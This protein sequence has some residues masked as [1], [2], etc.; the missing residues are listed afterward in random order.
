[1]TP[2]SSG[3]VVD[4]VTG[5]ALADAS[6]ALL[7]AAEVADSESIYTTF[8]VEGDPQMTGSDGAYSFAAGDGIYRIDVVRDGYQPYRTNDIDGSTASVNQTIALSPQIAA[9][10]AQT[11]YITANG[12]T[13]ATLTVA[14]G[15]VIEFI[16]V[17]LAD[18]GVSNGVWNSGLLATGQS[19]KA[20]VGQTGTATYVDTTD[21]FTKGT[22]TVESDSLGDANTIY[23][24]V[25]QK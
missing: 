7:R 14:P 3:T 15:S 10:T 11:V 4:V 1:M 21:L 22:V 5:Q 12:F 23:L 8:A 20:Q 17:D 18:H 16:N 19:F 24:P 25:V 13:P 9:A 6:V 2:A